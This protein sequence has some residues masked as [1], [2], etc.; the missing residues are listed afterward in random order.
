MNTPLNTAFLISAI[1]LLS[2]FDVRGQSVADYNIV[3][4]SQSNN[5]SESMPCG[6]GDIGLNVW[7]ENDE[8]LFYISK[9]GAFDENNTLLKL[10]RMRIGITPNPFTDGSFRQEL[11]LKDGNI[12]IIAENDQIKAELDIWVDVF[13]P[14]AHVDINTSIPSE[15]EVGYESWRYKDRSLEGRAKFASS[16]K[17]R[18]KNVVTSKDTIYTSDRGVTFAHLNGGETIFNLT[19]DDQQLTPIKDQLYDPL[20]N[21]IFGGL[22]TGSNLKIGGIYEGVYMDTDFKGW[23]QISKE[24][25]KS[26]NVSVILHNEQLPSLSEWNNQLQKIIDTQSN[27][28]KLKKNTCNWWNDYWDRSHIR[29]DREEQDS[30]WQVGRNYQLFRY[31]LG[32]NAYGEWPT[33]FNGGLFTYDPSSVDSIYKFTPDHR[34]WGGGTHTAQNQRLVYFPMLRS[35]DFDM[36]IPQ[37]EF[38]LRILKNAELRSQYYWGHNGACFTEQIENFGLPNYAEYGSK[39]PENYDPG[40]QYNAWLEYQWDTVLEFCLMILETETYADKDISKYIPLIESSLTFF[41]EHYQY[42]ASKRGTKLLDQNGDLI[43]YPGSACETY[44]MTYNASATIAGLQVVLTRLLKSRYLPADH[45]NTWSDMLD[46]IPGIP[47]R[48]IENK[49]L[50][51]PAIH[52]ERINNTEAPQLYPVYP[53]G[54]FGVGKPGLDTAINTYRYDQDVQ[55][56]KTHIG[57]KQYSIW[58]ARLGM[59]YEAVEL[60]TLKLQDSGRRFPSFWGPGFDWIPDHNWG[61]SGALGLQEMLLQTT[62]DQL[63]LFPSWPK[64]WDVQFKLHA[65]F[66]TIIECELKEGKISKLQVTPKEREKDIKILLQ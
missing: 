24:P 39:R 10:G 40:M 18:G 32:C 23:K 49:V 25:S 41:N 51:S 47:Y 31:M 21:R 34:N 27:A 62:D 17:W 6:G 58:A 29:I 66:N 38:Y 50:I 52:W 5:S 56:F 48:K 44:K 53:W 9:S 63:L 3:W 35:G 30:V 20:S 14:V 42:L 28:K 36:M 22:V 59:V 26:H 43:L 16:Y 19:V 1:F 37:F 7:V 2:F 57:W 64:E 45:R 65:P 15:I 61:G 46:Q 4:E 55:K 60:T 12:V 8:L 54:L 13:S 33:K 11:N